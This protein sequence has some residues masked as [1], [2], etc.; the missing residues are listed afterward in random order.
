MNTA[1]GSDPNAHGLM[2]PDVTTA[3]AIHMLLAGITKLTWR[4][5]EER[6]QE[7]HP[8]LTGMPRTLRSVPQ[9]RSTSWPGQAARLA[10]V[11]R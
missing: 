10:T 6:M 2:P 9:R 11:V 1:A 7:V 5:I 4:Q 3:H 8:G